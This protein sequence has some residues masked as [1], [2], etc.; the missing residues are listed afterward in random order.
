[1]HTSQAEFRLLLRQDNAED[2]LSGQAYEVGLIDQERHAE[3]ARRRREVDEIVRRLEGRWLAPSDA[4]NRTLQE[5]G[6]RPLAQSVRAREFLCRTDVEIDVLQR[7]G[8]VPVD[9]V[10][11]VARE[12]ETTVK[13]AGYVARQEGEVNRLRKL[14]ERE[15][16]EWVDYTSIHGLRSEC[17]ERLQLVRP[18]TI[19]QASRVSGVAPSDVSVLLVHLERD[20]RRAVR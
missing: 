8:L 14:E 10:D 19:G 9:I 1:M 7:L 13:Y 15:I 20:R 2:R 11:E 12:V 17:R 6:C 5:V 4:T 18:R 16:P 3:I